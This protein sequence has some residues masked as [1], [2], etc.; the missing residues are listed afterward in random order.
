MKLSIR[1]KKNKSMS[2]YFI[3]GIGTGIGK[4]ITS[5]VIVEAM[6]FDYW[7]PIQSGDLDKSDTMKVRSLV[8]NKK[9]IFHPERFLLNSA[10]SP[11]VSAQIDEVE[12]NLTDFKLPNTRNNLII[13]GAGGLMVPINNK[14]DFMIDLIKHLGLEV[15]LVTSNYL[16]SINHTILSINAIRQKNIQLKGVVVNG[17]SNSESEMIIEKFSGMPILFRIPHLEHI[18]ANE[19]SSLTN[20]VKL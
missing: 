8:Q 17:A 10:L 9:T 11:H 16:G 19:I 12:M 20:V 13:E 18:N 4:T 2:A 1:N 7:K 15:I 14:P 6:Q 5:A 3:T